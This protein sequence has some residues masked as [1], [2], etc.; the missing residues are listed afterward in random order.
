MSKMR[1]LLP[2]VAA[3]GLAGGVA[4]GATIPSVTGILEPSQMQAII[5]SLI[6]SI[7]QLNGGTVT[8]GVTPTSGFVSGDLI[9]STGGFATDSGVLLSNV[10]TLNVAHTWSAAQTFTAVIGSSYQL[11]NVTVSSTVP[12][13]IPNKS[14]T[15]TGLGSQNAGNLSLIVGST[16]IVRVTGTALTQIAGQTVS[17][18]YTVGTLP[19]GI[20]G[21]RAHVTDQTTTCAVPG[22][23]LVG[24]GAV[25]C[26]VFYNGT[27]WVG[28]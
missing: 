9:Y 2:T 28:G 1:K 3:I 7:N 24:G 14:S 18:G 10:P 11:A 23:A 20:V 15:A 12:S 27:A 25:T 21:G 19:S 4:W 5:N 22:G 6:Q 26:P 8:S 17:A 13:I 16:E